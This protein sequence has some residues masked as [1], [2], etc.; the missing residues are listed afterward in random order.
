MLGGEVRPKR[1]IALVASRMDI[2]RATSGAGAGMDGFGGSITGGGGGGGSIGRAANEG[3]P[4]KAR[5]L[6]GESGGGGGIGNIVSTK[7]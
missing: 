3:S 2:S 4:S 1:A 6:I 5:L 7:C